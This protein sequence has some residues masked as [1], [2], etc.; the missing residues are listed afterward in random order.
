MLWRGI[1]IYLR[2]V[3]IR[4]CHGVD[5]AWAF[6][7]AH[8]PVMHHYHNQTDICTLPTMN[9]EWYG[10]HVQI[11]GQYIKGECCSI[12]VTLGRPDQ[13]IVARPAVPMANCFLRSQNRTNGVI[14]NAKPEP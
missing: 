10:M 4:E 1:F 12:L 11:S 8:C 14:L 6:R 3:D 5:R 2:V 13:C 7:V 9:W